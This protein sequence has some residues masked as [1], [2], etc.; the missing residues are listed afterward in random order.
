M[1]QQYSKAIGQLVRPSQPPKSKC[2]IRVVLVTCIVFIYLEL[3]RGRYGAA[4]THL[5]NGLKLLKESQLNGN[6]EPQQC[7]ESTDDS[8]V[9]AFFRVYVQDQLLIQPSQLP[10]L[11]FM[12]NGIDIPTPT[13]KSPLQARQYLHLL[14]NEIFLLTEQA[15]RQAISDPATTS[16]E[17][18]DHQHFILSKLASWRETHKASKASFLSYQ[19]VRGGFIF[20]TLC[21][22][23]FMATI[24][25]HTCLS[26]SSEWLYS[27]HTNSFVTMILKAIYLRK[28]APKLT[29]IMHGHTAE[30]SKTIVDMGWIPPLYYIAVKC[31]VHRVRLQAIK[32]L[33]STGGNHREGIWDS[34]MAAC[35]ARKVVEVEERNFYAGLSIDDDFA[36]DSAPGERDFLLPA[37]PEEY[38]IHDVQ[39][40]LPGDRMGKIVLSF[41]QEEKHCLWEYDLVSN[42]WIE[43]GEHH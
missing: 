21:I 35:V 10:L 36:F 9:E 17:L 26:P 11:S 15:K 2:S 42:C 13:F 14:L 37:L 24:M 38:L 23:H 22:Y 6:F 33:E 29:E 19:P 28:H 5:N 34:K 25:R 41:C 31:R 4:Q 8:I 30:K 43:R 40:A 16:L 20:E 3:L 12:T 7:G 18:V 1:L 32:L 39:V 27:S